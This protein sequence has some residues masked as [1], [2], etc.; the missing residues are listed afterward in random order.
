ML[1]FLTPWAKLI[2]PQ[3]RQT[4][5]PAA[6]AATGPKILSPTVSVTKQVCGPITPFTPKS[7]QSP[8][9]PAASPEILHYTVR[10]TWLFIAYSLERWLHYQF[11]LASLIHFSLGR[12]GECIFEL[13]SESAKPFTA[14]LKKNS[15]SQPFQEKFI[16]SSVYRAKFAFSTFNLSKWKAKFFIHVVITELPGEAAGEIWHCDHSIERSWRVL[17]ART[18]SYFIDWNEK[19]KTEQ[20]VFGFFCFVFFLPPLLL[21]PG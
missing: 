4:R 11:S 7:D 10:R 15:F 20:E 8:I 14:K 12:L 16:N 9:S 17:S 6:T 2:S 18:Y 3:H 5:S 13:G 19:P 21:T 1:H